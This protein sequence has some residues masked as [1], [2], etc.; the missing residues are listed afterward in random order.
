MTR[1]GGAVN[2]RKCYTVYT[3]KHSHFYYIRY[4]VYRIPYFTAHMPLPMFA[5][6]THNNTHTG[7]IGAKAG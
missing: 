4:S 2:R 6:I 1:E 5:G 3:R 7:Q